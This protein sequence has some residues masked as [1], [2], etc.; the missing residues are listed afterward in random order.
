MNADLTKIKGDRKKYLKKY[1][2]RHT[3]LCVTLDNSSDKDIID[4]LS[5]QQNRSQAVRGA[6]REVANEIKR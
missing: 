4:W 6:L 1:M 5:A 2:E 3:T